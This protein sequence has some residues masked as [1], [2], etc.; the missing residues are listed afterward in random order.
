MDS[1]GLKDKE[2]NNKKKYIIMDCI[3]IAVLALLPFLHLAF[4]VEFTDTGY[5]FGNF[6]NLDKMNLTW[7]VA[8]F[9]ANMLGKLFG[10]LPFGSTWI[11]MKFYTTL[12]PVAGVVSSY[13]FLKKYVQRVIVFI[14]E[15]LTISLFWC[16]TALIYNYLTYLL[17]ALAV[18]I[19]IESLTKEKRWGLFIAGIILAFNVFVRFPNITETALILV[20]WLNS[21]TLRKKFKH[22]FLDTLT[23]VG[24]F[25]SGIGIN[26]LIVGL[27]YGFSSIPN[28]VISL[29]SMTGENSG[30]K[31][32]QMVFAMIKGY[33]VNYKSFIFIIA[34]TVICFAV[35]ALMKRH[36]ARILTIIA[37]FV[38]Y[39]LF[40]F[41]GYRNHV[42]TLRYA[43]YPSMYFWMIVFFAIGNIV[44]VWTLLRKRTDRTHK[45]LAAAVLVII[46]IT[47]LG[48]NNAL[49]PIMNNLFIVGPM[50]LFMCWN[51]LFKGRNFYELLDLEA[52][53]TMVATRITVALLLVT[54]FVNCFLFGIVFIFRDSGFPYNNHTKIEGN[55]VLVGMHTNPERAAIVEELTVYIESNGYKGKKAVYYGDIP[56][57]E[58]I[59]K[60]PCA[61]S[62]TW[63]DLG[64]FSYGE[65]AEDFEKLDE[66]PVVFVNTDYCKNILEVDED[67]PNKKNVFL[68]KYMG[69]NGYSL[70]ARIGNIAIY[71][72][73]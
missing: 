59:L 23:C 63:P 18:I 51:E 43:E 67:D 13:L 61:I 71:T 31:P 26:V 41:W 33:S 34:I 46:W 4:G 62:H 73:N 58:Y 48:S 9:W 19:L 52:K 56:G 70:E 55:E 72:A 39:G 49:Y 29:F 7:T 1:T 32:S 27:M 66:K 3:F 21:K 36:Y 11:G 10:R 65:F 42:Y 5:N 25:F 8:T 68:S 17:F 35:S 12:L 57:L 24:G 53:N 45:L 22:A 2:K 37:Q 14:G 16:P 54:I 64:S 38:L 60:M 15:L 6:E 44:S 30:Y 69:S 28:M 20:V 47:P 50:V 40:L